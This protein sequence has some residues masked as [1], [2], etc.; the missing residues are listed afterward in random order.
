[1]LLVM[2]VVTVVALTS[3]KEG[4]LVVDVRFRV[5]VFLVLDSVRVSVGDVSNSF[6]ELKD[7]EC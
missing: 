4:V 1:M 5:A 6:N 7:A 3:N 2:L